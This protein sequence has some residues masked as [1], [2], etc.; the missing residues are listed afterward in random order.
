ML[1]SANFGRSAVT[2]LYPCRATGWAQHQRPKTSCSLAG[3]SEAQHACMGQHHS[4]FPVPVHPGKAIFQPPA[5]LRN[6]LR[7]CSAVPGVLKSS[8]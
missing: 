7:T 2:L 1:L 5:G 4:K 3:P 8:A 6:S